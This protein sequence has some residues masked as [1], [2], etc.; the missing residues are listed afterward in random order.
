[1]REQVIEILSRT[2]P[3]VDF[4]NADALVDDGILDSLSIV[5]IIS[6]LSM[7]FD[8]IFDLNDLTPENLNSVDAIV[9]TIK[10]MKK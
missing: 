3:Q 9:A 8:I 4:E 10:K 6:E 7:E 1:M 2:L 5:T